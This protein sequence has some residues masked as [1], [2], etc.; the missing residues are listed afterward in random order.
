MFAKRSIALGIV[1]TCVALLTGCMTKRT[2]VFEQQR[3]S[4]V[5]ISK[6]G[7]GI[8][9]NHPMMIAPVRLSHILSRIDIRLSVEEGQ[10]RV[11]AFH[12]DALDLI[13]QALAKGLSEAAPNE[14]V[15][16]S[17]TRREKRFGIFD[18]TFL[19]N[20]I[21]YM[22]RDNLFIH[23]SRSDWEIPP[24]RKNKLPEPTIGKFPTKFRILPSKAMK[25]V[26]EQSLAIAWDDEVFQR[27][28]RTRMTPS[29]QMVR[30]TIL[31]ESDNF[32]DEPDAA[33]PVGMPGIPAGTSSKA[34]RELADLEDRRQRGEVSEFEYERQRKKIL[35][36][37]LA[38][39]AN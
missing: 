36:A 8:E 2:L 9:F 39:K 21:A 6:R 4:A 24:R 29:G 28:S 27:P 10:Q 12:I 15:I 33:Q 7:E 38:S 22:Y 1:V 11:P 17:S 32:D 34:L 23:L 5:L 26:D 35:D 13:S 30:K 20:F 31:M 14:R 18:T 19:T 16:I 3:T 37:D 25:M